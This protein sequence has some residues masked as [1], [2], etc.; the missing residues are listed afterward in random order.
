[1]S[2]I[3]VAPFVDVMLVLV[4]IFMI[5]APLVTIGVPV[6]LPD[7][8]AKPINEEVEPLVVTIDKDGRI[9]LQEA[10]TEIGALVPRLVA[11]SESNPELRIYVRGDQAITYGQVM[12]VIGLVNGA[13]FTKVAL[14]AE[15][16]KPGTKDH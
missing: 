4:I 5:T 16:P 10:E 15:A 14:I 11:V 7:A 13:G 2:E 12:K 9:F 3:N 1:M 8:E 6:D